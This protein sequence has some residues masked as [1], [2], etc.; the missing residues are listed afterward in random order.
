MCVQPARPSSKKQPFH[1]I[2]PLMNDFLSTV[3]FVFFWVQ[4]L[5]MYYILYMLE[6]EATDND[7][8]LYNCLKLKTTQNAG[9]L[10][11]WRS[12]YDIKI[13]ILISDHFINFA[14]CHSR[15]FFANCCSG[16]YWQMVALSLFLY[17]FEFGLYCNSKATFI[18]IWVFISFLR[19]LSTPPGPIQALNPK[20][21]TI[22]KV[23]N[24]RGQQHFYFLHLYFYFLHRGRPPSWLQMLFASAFLLPVSNSTKGSSFPGWCYT[25]SFLSLVDLPLICF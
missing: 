18:W 5:R 13:I 15:S 9:H 3:H 2:E 23:E 7:Q 24:Y 6:E 14:N 12:S 1:S 25:L 4:S 20:T 11:I 22:T 16:S 19:V 17:W 10:L 21:W 8:T